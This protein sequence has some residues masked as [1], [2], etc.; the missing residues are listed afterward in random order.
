TIRFA[1]CRS[2]SS[3]TL[4]MSTGSSG[5]RDL[6]AID[7]SGHETVKFVLGP[8]LGEERGRQYDHSRGMIRPRA[9]QR[10]TAPPEQ[11]ANLACCRT[12]AGQLFGGCGIPRLTGDPWPLS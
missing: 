9:R 10:V 8:V 5:S 4:F 7:T 6:G 12:G 3:T 2:S 11:G 1:F